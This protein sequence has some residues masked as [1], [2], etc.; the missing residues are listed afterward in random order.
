MHFL[1]I[2]QLKTVIDEMKVD[3]RN[4]EIDNFY[5]YRIQKLIRFARDLVM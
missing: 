1:E 2:I 5:N 3:L 4:F